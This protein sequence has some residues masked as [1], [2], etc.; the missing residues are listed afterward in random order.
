MPWSHD[1]LIAVGACP[2]FSNTWLVGVFL[3]PLDGMLV[4][5]NSLPH[6]LLGTH[7]YS[8]VERGTVRVKC[9]AQEHNTMSLARAWTRTARFGDKRT[10]HAATVSNQEQNYS[11]RLRKRKLLLVQLPEWKVKKIKGLR[12]QDSIVISPDLYTHTCSVKVLPKK[13]QRVLEN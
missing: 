7:L 1:W 11:V 12:N 4:R 6:N 8:W 13:H 9:L 3:L 5:R 10:N 2:G